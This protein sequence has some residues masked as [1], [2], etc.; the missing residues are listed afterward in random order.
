MLLRAEVKAT[1]LAR[2]SGPWH[3]L[4]VGDEAR[5]RIY[6]SFMRLQSKTG[7]VKTFAVMTDKRT[8]YVTASEVVEA[9]WRRTFERIER[10]ATNSGETVMLVADASGAAPTIRKLARRMRRH[11]FVGSML[12]T[13]ALERPLANVL[14]DDPYQKKS[15]ESYFIQLADL[16]AYAAYRRVIATPDFPRMMWHE[17]EDAIVWQANR[18]S[19]GPAGI[20]MDKSLTAVLATA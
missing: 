20:V 8:G 11:N 15:H 18:Y 10:F 13:P 12:G 2:G 17:L 16:N 5:H 9:T 19:G 14:I 7:R 6:R 4:G 3:G 1:D